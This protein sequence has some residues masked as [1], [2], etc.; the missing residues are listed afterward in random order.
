MYDDKGEDGP[1][2]E[3]DLKDD[4]GEEG[5]RV[6]KDVD[7]QETPTRWNEAFLVASADNNRRGD[8]NWDILQN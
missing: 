1:R 2:V 5:P 7:E 6:E 4:K 8:I 3:K